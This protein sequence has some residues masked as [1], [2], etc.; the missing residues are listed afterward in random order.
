MTIQRDTN[1]IVWTGEA[2][3]SALCQ[4]PLEVGVCNPLPSENPNTSHKFHQGPPLHPLRLSLPCW[5]HSLGCG[6]L[7]GCYSPPASCTPSSKSCFCHPV[8]YLVYL[9]FIPPHL[10]ASPAAQET[11]GRPR[12]GIP[13]VGQ[14]LL[15]LY[16]GYQEGCQPTQ[17]LSGG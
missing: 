8:G 1:I 12:F 5:R 16:G 7:P 6:Q 4:L 3:G 14:E 9:D 13:A 10:P 17:E 15:Q 11:D 2:M